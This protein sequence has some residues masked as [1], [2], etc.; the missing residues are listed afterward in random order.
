[1]LLGVLS[2]MLRRIL[3]RDSNFNSNFYKDK[4]SWTRKFVRN[5]IKVIEA[6]YSRFPTKNRW[7]CNCHV[8]HDDDRD[9]FMIDYSFLRE[10]YTKV[11]KKFCYENGYELVSLSDIWYNYY[12]MGQYQEP[13]DH[14]G[15]VKDGRFNFTAVHYLIFDKN[16]H[17][18]TKFC[19]STIVAPKVKQG[20]IIFF[21][22]P[23]R[24]YVPENTSTSSR[25]TTAF[26]FLVKN[27]NTK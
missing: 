8:I 22:A 16:K 2:K 23:W 25:L 7:N 3:S 4:L 20:D 13:H 26:T 21:P 10:E 6:N 24:H 18:Q 27:A 12:K 15:N 17:S 5:N 14:L 11:C 1:M 19:D 9:A